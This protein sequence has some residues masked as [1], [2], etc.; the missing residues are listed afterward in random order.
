MMLFAG[1]AFSADKSAEMSGDE[2]T[3]MLLS[4]ADT[5]SLA[6][7]E[8]ALRHG[9]RIDESRM[10]WTGADG[11]PALVAA[12]LRGHASIVS[13]LLERG[14][15][16]LVTEKDGF[17]VWHA[18]AFQGHPSVLRI[19]IDAEVPGYGINQRDGFTPLHRASW[20]R[21]QRHFQAVKLLVT[22]GGRACDEP[23]RAG[24]SAAGIAKNP[25]AA[26]WL[27]ACSAERAGS[28]ERAESAEVPSA[29]AA[30]TNAAKLSGHKKGTR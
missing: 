3:R 6:R 8:E 23:D 19:L 27:K 16:P 20:G 13:L 28:A 21:A 1:S 2:A 30:G 26:A 25:Q 7:V 17:N 5:G 15:D 4:A 9:A 11:Q 24:R 12:A 10:P 14:G 22:K 18:A 29:S